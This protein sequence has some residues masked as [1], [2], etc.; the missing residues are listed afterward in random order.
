MINSNFR[1][2]ML[3][4]FLSQGGDW[5]Y[6]VAL[7]LLVYQNTKDVV[8]M[9]AVYATTFAPYL[10]VTPFGG[11]IA[12]RYHKKAVLLLGDLLS[13]IFVFALGLLSSSNFSIALLPLVLIIASI[14][15]MSHPSF[16]SI[17]PE[18]VKQNELS[19]ANS[20]ISSAE[21]L[22]TIIGP[23]FAGVLVAS[24][25]AV[26]TIYLNAI[27]FLISFLIIF[28]IRYQQ[29]QITQN[30]NQS[31]LKDIREGFYETGRNQIIKYACLL[32]F[33]ENFAIHIFEGNLF[34]FLKDTLKVTNSQ[35]GI[36]LS[37]GGI[38]AIIGSLCT[39][40]LTKL[41]SEGRL[42][43]ICS[44]LSGI[45]GLLITLSKNWLQFSISWGFVLGLNSIIAV[46]YFTL[47]Q[48]VV[49]INLLGRVVSITRLIAYAA[50]PIATIAGSFLIKSQGIEV[51]IIIF[52][53][54][55]IACGC[56]GWLT[57]L[58]NN[59]RVI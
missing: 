13:T 27:S 59:E 3:A 51:V 15:C 36:A 39:P 58:S 6:K 56:L 2:L 24:I 17:I 11:A 4:F 34:F 37:L 8:A 9:G 10:F 55:M 41:L 12:D 28:Q 25:G 38:G 14:D 33:F 52:G 16:N 45:S 57:P 18:I 35:L 22:I 32:F 44:I 54:I 19:K 49:D 48:K 20:Y 42:I 46:T 30:P 21:S 53:S 26:N 23:L 31:I 29:R 50:I 47:R 7:P 5:L 40:K 1:K 43:L